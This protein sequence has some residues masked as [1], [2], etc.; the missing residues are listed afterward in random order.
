MAIAVYIDTRGGSGA[1]A[2]SGMECLVTVVNG[3][4]PLAIVTKHSILDVAAA[5]DPPLDTKH[6]LSHDNNL[7]PFYL[8]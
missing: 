1:A 6:S 3:F 5:L 4:Q 2:V 7:V 8:W